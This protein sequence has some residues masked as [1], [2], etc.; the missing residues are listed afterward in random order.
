MPTWK[1]RMEDRGMT[2]EDSVRNGTVV[3]M[4]WFFANLATPLW[5]DMVR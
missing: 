3:L 5:I 1:Q 2:L 4:F